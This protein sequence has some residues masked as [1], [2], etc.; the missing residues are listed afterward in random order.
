MKLLFL[1][2]LLLND[3]GVRAADVQV[4]PTLSGTGLFLSTAALL[5]TVELIP[6]E[7]NSPLWS[8]GAAKKRWMKIPEGQ[9]I[10]FAQEGAWDLPT[11]T[12][13]IKHFEINLGAPTLRRL[14]TRL[15]IRRDTQWEAYTYKWNA[16]QTDAELLSPSPYSERLTHANGYTQRW[17]YPSQAQCFECHQNSRGIALGFNTL[18]LG[19]KNAS[20]IQAWNELRLF[21]EDISNSRL[22]AYADPSD[23]TQS[24]SV[25]ARSY[26]AANCMHCHYTL[27]NTQVPIDLS[28]NVPVGKMQI[29]DAVPH[30]SDLG[31]PGGKLVVPGNKELS[32][33]WHRMKS[34]GPERMPFLGSRV[35]DPLGVEL[36]GQWI[37]AGAP[38]TP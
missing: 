16:G 35:V 14:E 28:F 31:I 5:P 15:L 27:E 24:L 37:D 13:L 34:T 2:V 7:V 17:M 22:V 18:Q 9:R 25:R 6:Y 32:I 12:I 4:A 21:S 33:L 23:A 30:A 3:K 26:L 19:G 11:G 20:Q 36:I 1:L 38:E 8:D 29:L 10:S